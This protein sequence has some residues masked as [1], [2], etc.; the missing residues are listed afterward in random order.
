VQAAISTTKTPQLVVEEL[1][2][3]KFK[4][5]SRREMSVGRKVTVPSEAAQDV[6]Q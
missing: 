5:Q 6:G 1:K 2:D 4:K 3:Q